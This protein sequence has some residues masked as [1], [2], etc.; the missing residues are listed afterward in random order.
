MT[1]ERVRVRSVT[2]LGRF[3]VRL[4]FTDGSECTVDLEPYLRGPGL[5]PLTHD[6]AQFA[7]VGIDPEQGTIVWP[8][9]EDIA[10]EVLRET[11]PA[12]PTPPAASRR[13]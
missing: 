3:E 5:A 13:R 12:G 11:A 7:G 10:P 8:D 1:A 4:A 6:P 9:G 2:V